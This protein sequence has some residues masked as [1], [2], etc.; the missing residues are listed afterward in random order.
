MGVY[1][2]LFA[3]STSVKLLPLFSFFPLLKHIVR[4]W[5]KKHYATIAPTFQKRID[6]VYRKW[7]EVCDSKGGESNAR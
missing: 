6:A 3:T 4:L 2:S 5:V 1:Y 7:Y